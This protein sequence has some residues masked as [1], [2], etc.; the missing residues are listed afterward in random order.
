MENKTAKVAIVKGECGHEPVFKTLD[1]ID[2]KSALT[3]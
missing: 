2:Y 3:G 1:L